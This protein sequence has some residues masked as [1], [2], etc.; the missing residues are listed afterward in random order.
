MTHLRF[1]AACLA[2]AISMTAWA[3]PTDSEQ[4]VN[5]EAD[6]AEAD[7]IRRI[8]IYKGRVIV[9]QGSI[10]ITG[11]VVT[12]YYNEARE[13]S[14]LVSVGRPAR[15]RQQV[16]ETGVIQRA[17]ALRIEYLVPTDTMILLNDATLSEGGSKVSADRIVYDTLNGRLKAEAKPSVAAKK[18]STKKPQKKTR[19]RITIEPDKTPKKPKKP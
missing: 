6:W 16:D 15:F 11:D 3:L 9:I 13:L 19:V 2:L 10:R 4:P 8:T 12:F 5:I 18:G 7:E 17:R 1:I 14:K